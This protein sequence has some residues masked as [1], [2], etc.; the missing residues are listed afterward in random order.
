MYVHYGIFIIHA[1]ANEI[2]VPLND[3]CP[4]ITGQLKPTPI[5]IV[6]PLTRVLWGYPED[7]D[8]MQYKML[9]AITK[10]GVKVSVPFM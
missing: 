8:Y 9:F 4:I 3:T 5:N 6:Y 1:Y 10:T 7:D 2:S